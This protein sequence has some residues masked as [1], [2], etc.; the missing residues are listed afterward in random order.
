[1]VL[2]A[3]HRH[4][5]LPDA[6]VKFYVDADSRR[7]AMRRRDELQAA[8]VDSDLETIEAEIRERDHLD[9]TRRDSPLTRAP[10][11]VH[12]DT[13]TLTPE[14]VLARMLEALKARE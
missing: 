9:S 8:G 4:G 14:E 5:R 13:T 12:L 7:R 6:D 3:G 1:V 2:T 10:G 11:A